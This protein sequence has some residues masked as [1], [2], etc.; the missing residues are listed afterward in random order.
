M[1]TSSAVGWGY[2]W[3]VLRATAARGTQHPYTCVTWTAGI[4]LTMQAH[5][6]FAYVK[7]YEMMH[8]N[9]MHALHVARVVH[10]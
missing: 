2:L 4:I 9:T 8:V 5:M 3:A 6:G 1:R 10:M 7:M